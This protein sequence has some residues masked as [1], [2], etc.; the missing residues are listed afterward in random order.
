MHKHDTKQAPLTLVDNTKPSD[1][2]NMPKV[3]QGNQQ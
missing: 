2:T 3:S 1:E